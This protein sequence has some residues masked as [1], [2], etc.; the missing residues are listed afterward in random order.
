MEKGRSQV[1]RIATMEGNNS[2]EEDL[3][4]SAFRTADHFN[5]RQ[6]SIKIGEICEAKKRHW[7]VEN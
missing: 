1:K 4:N 6:S 2:T 5:R 3:A 7:I